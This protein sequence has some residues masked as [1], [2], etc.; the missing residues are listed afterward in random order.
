MKE[1]ELLLMSTEDELRGQPSLPVSS[2]CGLEEQWLA[3][4]LFE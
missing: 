2:C 3:P 4:G 1:I